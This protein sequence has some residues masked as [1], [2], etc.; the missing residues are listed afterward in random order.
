MLL[1]YGCSFSPFIKKASWTFSLSLSLSF[2]SKMIHSQRPT[3]KSHRY[4]IPHHRNDYYPH[5]YG[6]L[7][8]PDSSLWPDAPEDSSSYFYPYYSNHPYVERQ[9][10]LKSSSSR[11]L[12]FQSSK[13]RNSY[14][15]SL[16]EVSRAEFLQKGT[17]FHV[18]EFK[19]LGPFNALP[20]FFLS[21]FL[22][23]ITILMH[24]LKRKPIIVDLR[25]TD[26]SWLEVTVTSKTQ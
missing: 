1:L 7:S 17:C 15:A 10:S 16:R 14:H 3:A 2:F 6:T 18:A 26:M 11:R 13:R 12:S 23:F 20:F 4:S 24:W 19:V 9:A 22:S 25:P 5:R 21:F 8:S